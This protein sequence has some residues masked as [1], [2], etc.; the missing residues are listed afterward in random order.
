MMDNKDSDSEVEENRKQVQR[1][2]SKKEEQTKRKGSDNSKGIFQQTMPPNADDDQALRELQVE[3]ID[4]FGLLPDPIKN[5][6]R[7]T[8][9]KLT[10]ERLGIVKV[11]AGPNGGKLEFAKEPNVDPLSIIKMVQTQPQK[12]QLAGASS[13][14]FLHDMETTEQRLGATE[15]LIASLEP[16]QSPR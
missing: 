6:F 13:L 8:S 12:Y 16:V 4:R 10:S 2:L 1:K 15:Q 7:T 14:K 9:I 5:L 11:E 3:M